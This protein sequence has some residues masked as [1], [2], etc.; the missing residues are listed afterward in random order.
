[1]SIV[2]C[3]KKLFCNHCKPSRHDFNVNRDVSAGVAVE[4]ERDCQLGSRVGGFDA[5]SFSSQHRT[6]GEKPVRAEHLGKRR[7]NQSGKQ[8]AGAKNAQVQLAIVG[9]GFG[10]QRNAPAVSRNVANKRPASD[11]FFFHFSRLVE[12][13]DFEFREFISADR[14]EYRLDIRHVID[15]RPF[16]IAH[17]GGMHLVDDLGVEAAPD[18]RQEQMTVD[19]CGVER[20]GRSRPDD[21]RHFNGVCTVFELFRQKVCRPAGQKRQRNA[22]YGSIGQFCG[23]AVAADADQ[24]VQ[25]PGFKQLVRP[26]SDFRQIGFDFHL[27]PKLLLERLDEGINPAGTIAPPRLRVD[28]NYNS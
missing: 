16:G 13:D 12:N 24:S 14:F 21:S 1:M 25:R 8:I 9:N 26:L 23:S 6:A 22:R 19:R 2:K 17:S 11:N 27:E 7:Q 20:F 4:L 10:S 5:E 15:M 3:L 28:A 18:H